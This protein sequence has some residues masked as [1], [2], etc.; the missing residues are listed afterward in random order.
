MNKNNDL[1]NR[2]EAKIVE[3]LENNNNKGF[4]QRCFHRYRDK[5]GFNDWSMNFQI[6]HN[7]FF[8]F[9]FAALCFTIVILILTTY[10]ADHLNERLIGESKNIFE[11]QLE[12]VLHSS[13]VKQM[14]ITKSVS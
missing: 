12:N 10:I 8:L 7:I 1:E 13:T 11:T 14:N 6:L 2:T 4:R 3:V 5:I 9:L